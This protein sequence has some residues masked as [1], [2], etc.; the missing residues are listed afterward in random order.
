LFLSSK[1]GLCRNKEYKHCRYNLEELHSETL[2]GPDT[3]D[4]YFLYIG[5]SDS[6]GNISFFSPVIKSKKDHI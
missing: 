3:A 4:G 1:E 2:E 6:E 5:G